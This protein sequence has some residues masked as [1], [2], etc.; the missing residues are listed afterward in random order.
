MQIVLPNSPLALPVAASREHSGWSE[1]KAQ[2]CDPWDLFG[3]ANRVLSKIS[4]SGACPGYVGKP[5]VA[6]SHMSAF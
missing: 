1:S 3:H 4:V 6:V 2:C 5:A